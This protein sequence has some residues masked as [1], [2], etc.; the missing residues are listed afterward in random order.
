M[1]VYLTRKI[2]HVDMDAFY[3]SVEQR[4]NPELRDR[5]IAV[6]YD[7]KRGVIATANYEARQYGV[8][9]AV[10]SS[11]AKRL[12]PNLVLLSPRF[13]VYRSISRQV[14]AIF[15]DYTD[16]IE[17]IALDEAYLDVSQNKRN[18]SSAW[19]IAQ[20]IRDRILKETGL[21]ASAGVSYNKF[22]AKMASGLRKPDGQYL[23]LPEHGEQFIEKLAITKFHGIGPV[24]AKKMQNLGIH[25]GA[26]LKEWT[27]DTLQSQFGKQGLWYYQIAHGEDNRPVEPHRERKSISAETTFLDDATELGLVEEGLIKMVDEV[28][29]WNE[30]TKIYG[31]TITVKIKWADFEQS[32]RSHTEQAQIN[33]KA[34]FRD[35]ALQLIRSVFPLK[36]GIRLVGVSMSNF[37]PSIPLQITQTRLDLK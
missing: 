26:N 3:A 22:L 36:K 30:K 27:I 7:G 11:I 1:V 18:I 15:A 6:G 25:T 35:I 23:I 16:L 20:V 21:T 17:P 12:C 8:H 24:T 28:W 29:S 9:S 32:T 10:S 4:D 14:H 37:T 5:P 34:E 19:T 2:I 33:S 31:R 13:D